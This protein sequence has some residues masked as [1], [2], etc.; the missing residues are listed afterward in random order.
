MYIINIQY[1]SAWELMM[2]ED[3]GVEPVAFCVQSRRSIQLELIPHVF[4]K[5]FYYYNTKIFTM[6]N[7][8]MT[9]LYFIYA[10]LF[11][12][13]DYILSYKEENV[14]VLLIETHWS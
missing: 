10:V 8:K 2:V 12:Y 14:N 1:F 5:L 4:F 6:Q 7:L 11:L 9:L 13:Q 3:T